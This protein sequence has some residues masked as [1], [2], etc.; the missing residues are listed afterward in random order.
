MVAIAELLFK[1][2]RCL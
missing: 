1:A 2:I